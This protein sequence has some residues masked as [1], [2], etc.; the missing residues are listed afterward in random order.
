MKSGALLRNIIR[1]VLALLL[2]WAAVS[3]LAKPADF[4]A[5]LYAYQL[6]L[7]RDLLKIAAVVLPW[8]EL[9]CGL[10]LFGKLWTEATLTITLG[11][12][13]VFVLA[14]GQ[15]WARHLDI[16]CGCFDFSIFGLDARTSGMVQFFESVAFAFVRNATLACAA[17]FL[18]WK[19]LAR[20]ETEPVK[21]RPSS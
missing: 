8:T 13:V 19:E 21:T 9:L 5:S 10:L 14:T 3:K 18:L 11:L 6:P 20:R 15:A 7:P 1:G 2:L 16:S 12:L 4:L 17:G